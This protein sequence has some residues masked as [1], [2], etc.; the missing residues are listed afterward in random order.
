MTLQSGWIEGDVFV[1]R[2]GNTI[3]R[4]GDELADS[5]GVG[6]DT[7]G[8][9]ESCCKLR[10]VAGGSHGDGNRRIAAVGGGAVLK[11]D[12]EGLFHG[13]G[14]FT[15]GRVELPGDPMDG[16]MSDGGCRL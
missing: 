11:A 12:L 16:H 10:I 8:E 5:V 1:Q 14:V 4:F 7:F 6:D 9:E 3:G 2:N 13:D 15:G